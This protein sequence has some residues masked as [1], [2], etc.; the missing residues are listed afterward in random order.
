[1]QICDMH[2]PT[3]ALRVGGGA[4]RGMAHLH[5][6]AAP[7]R[8]AEAAARG[9]SLRGA[10]AGVRRMHVSRNLSRACGACMCAA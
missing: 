3:G 10:A 1:M 6:A 9:P 5:A 8:R 2:A 4:G 7:D